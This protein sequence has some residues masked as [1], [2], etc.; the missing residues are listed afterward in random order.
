MYNIFIVGP[1]HRSPKH[2]A[3]EEA[4]SVDQGAAAAF[5]RRLLAEQRHEVRQRVAVDLG[6]PGGSKRGRLGNPLKNGDLGC[7]NGKNV[8]QSCRIGDIDGKICP[9][10]EV[11]TI[12]WYKVEVFACKKGIMIGIQA[13]SYW[14][15][16]V[17]LIRMAVYQPFPLDLGLVC[18]WV[19][20]IKP[21][22][23]NG[24]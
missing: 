5:G 2:Q 16:V 11:L 13:T 7:F 8:G 3:F 14:D 10:I 20:H 1:S 23:L 24:I 4:P 22:S 12:G 18:F 15:Y 6:A 9:D 17:H 19:H 21:M